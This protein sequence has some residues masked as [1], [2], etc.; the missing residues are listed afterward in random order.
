[1]SLFDTSHTA[2]TR[3]TLGSV[4][5]YCLSSRVC[6]GSIP[7]VLLPV[8]AEIL[9]RYCRFWEHYGVMCSR[10]VPVQQT[11][12]PNIYQASLFSRVKIRA[13]LLSCHSS[14]SSK[15]YLG[16]HHYSCGTHTDAQ[17]GRTGGQTLEVY[18]TSIYGLIKHSISGFS[19]L[20]ILRVLAATTFLLQPVRKDV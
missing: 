17:Q 11:R 13:F 3:S 2:S 14:A 8:L 16:H 1:M 20:P 12:R 15:S 10:A 9:G 6:R 7:R 19:I 4:H 5:V 18:T